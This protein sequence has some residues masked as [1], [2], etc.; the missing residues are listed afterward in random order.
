[1]KIYEFVIYTIFFLVSQIIVEKELLPKYLTNKNLFKTSLIGVGFM[2]VGAIIGVFLKT[3]FI[4]ILFTILSSSLMAW[5]F[6]KNAD[7]FE[8]GAK[9]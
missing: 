3:R 1:M 9:I 8:R 4:P 6:R 7:D 5:K 2:L